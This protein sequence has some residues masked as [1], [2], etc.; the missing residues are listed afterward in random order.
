VENASTSIL[1]KLGFA[2]AGSAH[3]A[4]AGEVWEWHLHPGF[5]LR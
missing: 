2:L 3:D 5:R 4:D 1:R